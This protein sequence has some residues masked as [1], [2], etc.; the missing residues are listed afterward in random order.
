MIK[1]AMPLSKDDLRKHVYELATAFG[2]VVVEIEEVP[3]HGSIALVDPTRK[4]TPSIVLSPIVDESSYCVALHELGHCIAPNGIIQD[5][6]ERPRLR[7]YQEESAWEWAMHYAL[8]WTPSMQHTMMLCI[9]SYQ[10]A[11][12]EQRAL[13]AQGAKVDEQRSEQLRKFAKKLKL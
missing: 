5:A 3:R 4:A 10:R 11:A 1:R 13:E 7:L 2:V 9:G 12:A 6:N 8:D